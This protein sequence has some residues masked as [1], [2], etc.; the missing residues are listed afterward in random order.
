MQN[1]PIAKVLLSMAFILLALR[2]LAENASKT[3]NALLKI[4]PIKS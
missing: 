4:T 1:K 2:V 3:N